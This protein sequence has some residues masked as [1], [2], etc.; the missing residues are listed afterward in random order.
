MDEIQ[1]VL[2]KIGR[3]DLAQKYYEKVAKSRVAKSRDIKDIIK[4]NEKKIKDFV[5]SKSK[6]M[7]PEKLW[8]EI[9]TY[10]SNSG[11]MPYGVQKA[12]TGDPY[13]WVA[14]ALKKEI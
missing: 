10:Y 13:Q 8:E 2:V 14:K 12:R 6:K 1:K 5:T 7:L 4:G 11:D 9:Y 3:K